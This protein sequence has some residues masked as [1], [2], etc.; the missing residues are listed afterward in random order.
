VT[1]TAQVKLWTS[2][3]S[4]FH[5]LDCHRLTVAVEDGPRV[6]LEQV[7]RHLHRLLARFNTVG[8]GAEHLRSHRVEHD[9]DQ[10]DVL[11]AS[12]SAE[13]EAVAA[14]RERRRAV[15]VLRGVVAQVESYLTIY[16]VLK[17]QALKP[18][19]FN[20]SIN[21]VEQSWNG[22]WKWNGCGTVVERLWNGS[23]T[24]VERS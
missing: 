20:M 6:R 5:R 18:G 10:A 11:R 8:D 16:D 4:W 15:A 12:D 7:L 2:V 14:V 19:A 3:S 24:V 9:V 13:L 23:K 21:F 22:S 17:S 1:K